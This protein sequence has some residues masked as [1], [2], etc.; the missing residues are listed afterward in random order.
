MSSNLLTKV[1]ENNTAAIK[2]AAKQELGRTA[3]NLLADTLKPHLPM[4]VRGYAD[5]PIF[6]IALANVLS[7]AIQKYFSHNHKAVVVA[8][9]MMVAGY[10]EL[11][12]S[13][14]IEG[15]LKGLLDKLPT[16]KLNLLAEQE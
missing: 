14:D 3:I 9:A 10:S 13:F 16:D 12:R 6:K 15:M 7:A 11:F 5:S 8:D 2:E 4:M 1:A